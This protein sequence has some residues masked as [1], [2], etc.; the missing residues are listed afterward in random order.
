M[1]VQTVDRSISFFFCFN[2]R[3]FFIRTKKQQHFQRVRHFSPAI[4]SYIFLRIYT[5]IVILKYVFMYVLCTYICMYVHKYIPYIFMLFFPVWFWWAL[6]AH[7]QYFLLYSI[8]NHNIIIRFCTFCTI[9]FS[10][11]LCVLYL[12]QFVGFFVFFFSFFYIFIINSNRK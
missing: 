6:P 5:M 1:C 4:R 12:R 7:I 11:K 2:F 9:F 8:W 10:L 3:L